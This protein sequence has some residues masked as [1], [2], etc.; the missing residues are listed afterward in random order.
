MP[1]EKLVDDWKPIRLA[2]FESR[3]NTE[4]SALPADLLNTYKQHATA[5]TEQ[6]CFRSQQYGTERVFAV[7]RSDAR[8]LIF[9]DVEDELA[10]GVPD[11]DGVLRSWGLYGDL[12]DTLRAF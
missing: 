12:V 11:E 10:I 3:L 4:I 5:I 7:A 1:T 2:D 6:P 9:D 8:V